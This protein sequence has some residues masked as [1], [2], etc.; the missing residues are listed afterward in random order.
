MYSPVTNMTLSLICYI[1]NKF[2]ER[3]GLE[4]DTQADP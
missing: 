2:F 1:G 3:T 4:I